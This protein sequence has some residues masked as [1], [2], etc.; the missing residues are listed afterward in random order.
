[1]EGT[2]PRTEPNQETEQAGIVSGSQTSGST[3]GNPTAT[4][5]A[6]GS[7]QAN[8]PASTKYPYH[9]GNR[10]GRKTKS[11]QE[12]EDRIRFTSH[13]VGQRLFKG[14]IK[15][16]LK[17]RWG[18]NPKTAG[19]YITRAKRLLAR[20][21]GQSIEEHRMDSHAFYNSI[22]NHP[23]ATLRDKMWAQ[24]R[25]DALFGL[26]IHTIRHEG[27]DSKPVV[28]S[29]V[30]TDPVGLIERARQLV[31]EADAERE[32][33]QAITVDARPSTPSEEAK[34]EEGQ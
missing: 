29:S 31:K 23:S 5:Q 16:V 4:A 27:N 18:V 7:T 14:D 12:I 22:M 33:R 1:M 11:Q 6:H 19:T 15:R 24:Q 28:V 9:K 10:P 2:H 30:P 32:K 34:A 26:E 17:Q 8:K 13:L 20:Q 25:I 3:E 21:A